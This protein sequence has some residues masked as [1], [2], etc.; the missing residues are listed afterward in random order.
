MA[1]T[2]TITLTRRP[3]VTILKEDWPVLA[4]AHYHD[5]DGEHEFQAN[6]HWKGRLSVRQHEDGRAV[7]YAVCEHSTNWA[8]GRGYQ[9][10]AGDLLPA[11]ST[12]DA[13]IEAIRAVHARITV[14]DEDHAQDWA[15][16]A[17]ECIADL[18]AETL[19]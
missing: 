6:Q 13:I 4:S 5:Y 7:V 1:D 17:D 16:L 19:T 10:R 11:G 8:S 3:P 14:V 15:L 12:L 2:L 18:P 9:Q